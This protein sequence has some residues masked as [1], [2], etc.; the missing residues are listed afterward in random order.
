MI[1]TPF[2]QYSL[3]C[4]LPLIFILLSAALPTTALKSQSLSFFETFTDHAVLQ[5]KVAHPVWGRAVPKQRVRV[6]FG[7]EE[8]TTRSD[9]AG[10]WQ[11]TLPE[12]PKGGP[13]VLVAR[14][15]KDRIEISDLYF[16]DVYLLSGQS[17]MEWK[18]RQSDPD[19]SRAKA[20]ADPFVREV[21]VAKSTANA[22]DNSLEISDKWRRGTADYI[23]EFSAV[24]SYFA[25]YLRDRIDV[26]IGLIH[27]SWGGSRIEPWMP[28]HLL[29]LENVERPSNLSAL[30]APALERYQKDFG[31][32]ALPPRQDEG[33]ALGYL[34]PKTNYAD[35]PGIQVPGIWEENGYPKINGH[36]YLAKYFELSEAQANGDIT[37]KLG[38]IDD[39]DWTYVN[40]ELVGE[41]YAAYAEARSYVVPQKQLRA[42]RNIL[43]IRVEDTGGG[44]GL[45][46]APEDVR[47]E[48]V[49]GNIPL[50]GR[51]H[52]QVGSWNVEEQ[53]NQ[54][55]TILYNK[56]IHPLAGMPLTGV[57]WYQGES[58][59]GPESAEAYAEQ[60]KDLINYWRSHFQR[61]DLP[62]Y[63]VQLANFEEAQ[64]SP[65][66]TGWG[67]IRESQTAALELPHTA[68]AVIIDIGEA[69]DIHPRNKWE[70]GRRLALP[71]LKHIYGFEEIKATSPRLISAKREGKARVRLTLSNEDDLLMARDDRYGYA[72]GFVYRNQRGEWHWARAELLEGGKNI[73]VSSPSNQVIT[74]VRYGFANNPTD[75]NVFNGKGLPLTPFHVE[76]E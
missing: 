2:R 28:A 6:T 45:T 8:Y 54:I 59:A 52:Y 20:I 32:T 60:F 62:F 38:P 42:G 25:H 50:A 63:W 16:G 10:R 74:A 69:D 24:G 15:N 61:S 33:Q 71:A 5:R 35:W 23:G 4:L 43:L 36:F 19:G 67:T 11:I 37:L 40:G 46:A 13:H 72:K 3:A 76:I 66:E 31:A 30:E 51:W 47:I 39:S 14:T 12:Q 41:R 22:P 56:M 73:L 29:G 34:D 75:A 1:R 26:P 64:M 17:N 27:S 58:N 7:G 57:L 49:V 9:A 55:P 44:G 18:V 53:L 48:T 21:T 65:D 68:Q 70:V